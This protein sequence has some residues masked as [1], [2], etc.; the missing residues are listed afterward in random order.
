MKKADIIINIVHTIKM[1]S[2]KMYT[3][4]QHQIIDIL[5]LYIK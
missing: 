3:I 5:Y 1:Q 4:F 2:L